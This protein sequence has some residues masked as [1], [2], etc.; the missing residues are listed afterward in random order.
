MKKNNPTSPSAVI[1]QRIS[2]IDARRGY[3]ALLR[4][5]LITALIVYLLFSQVFM[6]MQTRGNTMFPALKDGDL[7]IAFRL[8]RD[9]VKDDIA[10]Y[11]FNDETRVGRVVAKGG[12]VVDIS[13][14]GTLVVNGTVQSGDIMYPTYP[15]DLLEYPC[16]VP[17]GHVFILGDYRVQSEDSRHFGPVP[18]EQ[19]KA[20]VITV[21]RRRGL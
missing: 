16:R 4:R 7:L 11:A 17:E 6:I 5:I 15:G 8:Q 13:E 12:D 10:V 21:L 18:A 9:Y 14:S 3:I 20:K 19:L 2:Q 1:K